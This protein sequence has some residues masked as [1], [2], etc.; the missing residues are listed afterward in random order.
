MADFPTGVYAPRTKE[1][2]TGVV[3]VA[4]KSTVGYAEDVTKLDDEVVAVETYLLRSPV[5]LEDVATPALDASLGNT[6]TLIATG[7]REIAVPT[8]SISG[9]KITIRHT[10]SGGARTLTLNTGAGGFRF[11]SDITS[12]AQTASGKTDW[13]GA[14]FHGIDSKWDVVAVV[15]GY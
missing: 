10:A 12:L 4:A 5:V 8:N 14:I 6:F 3:Y 1:N 7:D 2:K 11:G 13:V 9:Q 15:Q